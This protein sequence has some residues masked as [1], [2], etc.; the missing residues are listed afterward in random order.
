MIWPF[1]LK[2]VGFLLMFLSGAALLW[3]LRDWVRGRKEVP[4]PSDPERPRLVWIP[5]GFGKEAARLLDRFPPPYSC[6][7]PDH[8]ALCNAAEALGVR[9]GPRIRDW[10]KT[11]ARALTRKP[12][13]RR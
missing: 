7:D 1:V 2:L 6:G 12:K 3:M 9:M 5:S 8:D 13:R 11:W 10:A 4:T